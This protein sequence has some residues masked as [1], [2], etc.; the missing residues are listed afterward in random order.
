MGAAQPAGTQ[1]QVSS[2]RVLSKVPGA[3]VSAEGSPVAGVLSPVL[4]GGSVP[5]LV[6]LSAEQLAL[7]SE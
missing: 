6:G 7:Q 4:A 3:G 5:C 2:D 1:S